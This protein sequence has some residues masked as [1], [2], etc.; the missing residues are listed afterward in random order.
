MVRF[1]PLSAGVVAELLLTKGLVQD[2]AEARRLAQHGEGSVQRAL[3]LADPGL[4]AFRGTLYQRLAAPMLDS[5]RLAPGVSAFVE[6][7]GK[8]ASA[9]RGRL[10]QVIGFAAGFYQGLAAR[11]KR[12][13]IARRPRTAAFR[14]RGGASR[15]RLRR[16]GRRPAGSLPGRRW[17]RSTATPIKRR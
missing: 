14:R 17:S 3:E 11:R 13:R 15:A 4:W 16:G 7:A 9:R 2:A 6:E 10:R 5:V 1:R 12:R 8:E